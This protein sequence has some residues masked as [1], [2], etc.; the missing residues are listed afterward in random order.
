MGL[1]R[2]GEGSMRIVASCTNTRLLR[3][4]KRRKAKGPVSK[5]DPATSRLDG[6]ALEKLVS[7]FLFCLPLMV[8]MI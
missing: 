5:G 1:Q 6:G 3:R 8:A 7:G 2:A 4:R